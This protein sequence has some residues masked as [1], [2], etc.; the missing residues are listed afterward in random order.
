MRKNN[1][2]CMS[3]KITACLIGLGLVLAGCKSAGQETQ[4]AVVTGEEA[5]QTQETDMAPDE[6]EQG[7][8]AEGALG[9]ETEQP[10]ETEET[11]LEETEPE[12][13][14]TADASRLAD[15]VEDG[16]GLQVDGYLIQ[17]MKLERQI[18]SEDQ[19]W[20]YVTLSVQFP[21]VSNAAN[22]EAA[23][24]IN[25]VIQSEA[26]ALSN[27]TEYEEWAKEDF[28]WRETLEQEDGQTFFWQPYE[29]EMSYSVERAD[30][31]VIS[32]LFRNYDYIGGAH[33]GQALYGMTFDA[34]TGEKLTLEMLGESEQAVRDVVEPILMQQAEQ[35][36]EQFEK[37]ERDIGLFEEY[38]DYMPDVLTQESWYLTQD[39]M[40]VVAN[41]YLIAPYATGPVTF[42]I[43]YEQ[44]TFIK[45]AYLP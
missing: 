23:E 28:H 17:P 29:V 32:F 37:G 11:D 42:H 4:E 43:P 45:E 22:P 44:S 21:K 38:A 31:K 13:E 20:V 5:Q 9:Q 16:E 7:Q 25:A 36:Q 26:G 12:N 15:A 41:E 2:D 33:G 27:L 18:K 35:I 3:L 30:E 8:M 10:A 40:D 14:E 1:R 39:G 24:K 34:Q 19:E 6:E